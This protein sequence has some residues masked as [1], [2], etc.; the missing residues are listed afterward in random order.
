MNSIGRMWVAGQKEREGEDSSEIAKGIQKLIEKF[1]FATVARAFHRT[2]RIDKFKIYE[3][4]VAEAA[5]Q[6]K[7]IIKRIEE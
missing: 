7:K 1:G 2:H 5:R 3:V 4:S 6:E